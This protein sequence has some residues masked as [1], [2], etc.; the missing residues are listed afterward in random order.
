M[1][2]LILKELR[3]LR[4]FIWLILA[5][6]IA[7]TAYEFATSFPDE[8][9]LT[10]KR[11]VD[12][13]HGG[14][15]TLILALMLGSTLVIRESEEGTLAF[16]DGL[17][18]SRSRVFFAKVVGGFLV[19]MLIPIT[20]IG[21]EL[22]TGLLSRTSVDDPLPWSFLGLFTAA[23][24]VATAFALG[25]ALAL[26]F[27]RQWLIL[28]SGLLVWGFIWLRAKGE[29]WH[30]WLNPHTLFSGMDHSEATIPWGQIG[31]QT[32]V[33]AF[34]LLLAWILFCRTGSR[35]QDS[36]EAVSRNRLGRFALSAAKLC[37]PVVWFF[38]VGT[39][40]WSSEDDE[41]DDHSS[42]PLGESAFARHETAH[43][44]FLFRES[45]R[46][47]VE[48]LFESADAVYKQVGAYLPSERKERIVVDLASPVLP[49]AAALTNWTKIRFPVLGE[50]STD[51]VERVLAHETVHVLIHQIGDTGFSNAHRWTR[52][53]NEGLA[54]YLADSLHADETLKTNS[55]QLV[56][57]LAAR[58]K[59]PFTLLCDN[60]ILGNS[61]DAE[62][63]YP[64]GEVFCRALIEVAGDDAPARLLKEF[65]RQG[66]GHRLEGIA[67]WRAAFQG[68]GLNFDAV[69]AAYETEIERLLE[70]EAE[71]VKSIPRLTAKIETTEETIRVTPEYTGEAPGKIVCSLEKNMFLGKTPEWYRPGPDGVIEIPRKDVTEPELRYLL[72]WRIEGFPWP[73]I[74][75]PWASTRIQ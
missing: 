17:P 42:R 18:V 45:Q 3:A 19:L 32:G 8:N 72:G 68:C 10:A 71:F 57:A 39:A 12:E 46:E 67:L 28:V 25:T 62:L 30:L 56:A 29:T 69:T 58:G 70:E 66:L 43:Y 52:F 20:D 38:A 61:R 7:G 37:A 4:P 22:A 23:H 15:A 14:I 31:V 64:F 1:I 24:V 55:R 9:S 16:L 33:A 26:A 75:E 35:N 40:V 34:G 49:H 2:T 21:Y 73:V 5:L 6:S 13:T 47:L 36:L 50:D 54:Q 41:D 53:F 48:E 60:D 51:E 74:F 65:Q 27:L 63:V 11:L 59:V 44:E